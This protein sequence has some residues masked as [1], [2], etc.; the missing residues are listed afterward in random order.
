MTVLTLYPTEKIDHLV[1]PKSHE[2]LTKESP[3]LAIF[4]DFEMYNP[5]VLEENTSAIEAEKLMAK[6]HVRMKIVVDKSNNFL[7]IVSLKDLSEQEVIKK[8]SNGHERPNLMITDFMRKKSD[9]SAFDFDEL[10][11]ATIGDIVDA[12]EES[13]HQHCL[14]V[15]RDKHQIRGLIS[16]SDVARK[17]HIPIDISKKPTFMEV[18]SISRH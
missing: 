17:L 15:D 12:L 8:I 1:W 11:T 10:E 4:T 14:V 2:E 16:A 9:L 3:A 6:A 18:F 7:G 5:L 13:A